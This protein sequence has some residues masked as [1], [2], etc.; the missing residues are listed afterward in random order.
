M[1]RNDLVQKIEEAFSFLRTKYGFG[2]PVVKDYGRELFVE[3]ERNAETISISIEV[4][5]APLV[6]V[7]IPVEGTA[8]KS[9]PWTAKNNIQ[10][11]RLFP[12]LK[13]SRKFMPNDSEAVTEYLA[14]MAE[15]LDV[16]QA[17]W[18]NA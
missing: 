4:G 18:L 16:T 8:Y 1:E 2:Y 10:R 7:F 17:E 12:K 14:E 9:V 13:I 3:F 5:S 6:E 11:T 15:Q